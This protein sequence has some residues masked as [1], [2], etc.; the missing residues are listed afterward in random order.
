MFKW[1]NRRTSADIYY[2]LEEDVCIGLAIN[3]MA[4][5]LERIGSPAPVVRMYLPVDM[6]SGSYVVAG[7]MENPEFVKWAE[8]K[9][10]FSD[11]LGKWEK[12]KILIS[13]KNV[14]IA[15]SDRLGTMWGIYHI[16][17]HIF[18]VDPS[19]IF[20]DN[21]PAVRTELILE[22]NIIISKEFTFKFRGWFINSED[23][24]TDWIKGG[25]RRNLGLPRYGNVIHPV[26]MDR[27]IETMLRHRMNFFIPAS[28]IDIMNPPEE[29]IVR[30][31]T[32]R[33]LF[34][35]QHHNEPLG[36]SHFAFKE[37]WRKQGYDEE[38]SYVT[39][40]DKFIMTWNENISKWMKY[41]HVI[42]QLG[43]R[44]AADRPVWHDDPNVDK[45]QQGKGKLISEAISDQYNLVRE[46][47]GGRPFY[48]TATL[49][50]ENSALY[51]E[52]Y[53][54]YP[55][56]TMLIL[57]DIGLSQMFSADFY[58]TPRREGAKYGLYYHFGFMWSGPHIAQL[59]D[60]KKMEWN[61]RIAFGKGDTSYSVVNVGNIRDFIMQLQAYSD[62]CCDNEG[63]DSDRYLQGWCGRQFGERAAQKTA[64]IYRMYFDSLC[65]IDEKLVDSLFDFYSLEGKQ[66]PFK[67]RV[68]LD[69]QAL[70]EGVAMVH[71]IR[72]FIGK[73]EFDPYGH[74][75]K[76]N[77]SGFTSSSKS[78]VEGA[79]KYLDQCDRYPVREAI[80]NLRKTYTVA[81]EAYSMIREGSENFYTANII[82][83]IEIMMGLY[84][85]LLCAC[86]AARAVM[87][88]NDAAEGIRQLEEGIYVLEKIVADCRK[89]EYGIWE[90]WYRGM[91]RQSE[92][93]MEMMNIADYI[94]DTRLLVEQLLEQKEMT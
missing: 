13:G 36:V 31:V 58:E 11:L 50:L 79:L 21:K 67:K 76:Y 28:F 52:G 59:T 71:G 88:N 47:Y 38:P 90:N 7:S 77:R 70:K 19:I 66:L 89:A 41:R 42:W 2:N 26:V 29:D 17:E 15:G 84:R 16:C 10:D 61:Y 87:K 78:S 9:Y 39:N 43:L 75:I 91:G 55:E 12:Y 23:L 93:A 48:S 53:T 60:I 20:T 94:D 22:D 40:K 44:G 64:E 14:V 24:L 37:Y 35:S 62:I 25:G 1:F 81:N 82:V 83:Q 6:D 92:G 54:T 34:V 45:T 4:G 86:E 72:K 5:D 65:E 73:A 30:A 46:H 33:G 3:D 32:R 57:S 85:W 18:G 8:G 74:I 51:R 63:F 80:T 68:L 49:W 69:D 56:D 27:I